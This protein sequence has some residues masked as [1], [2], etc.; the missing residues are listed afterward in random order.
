MASSM[1]LTARAIR[2]AVSTRPAQACNMSPVAKSRWITV[3]LRLRAIR[4]RSSSIAPQTNSA[5]ASAPSEPT[6]HVRSGSID[7]AT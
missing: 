3:S 5:L 2:S 1:P 6:A 4:S 7:V